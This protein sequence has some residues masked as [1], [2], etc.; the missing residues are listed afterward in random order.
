M[1]RIILVMLPGF[2][3]LQ[4]DS[5]PEVN[6]SYRSWVTCFNSLQVD[7]KLKE[8]GYDPYIMI[9]FQFL[10]GRLKT[11][12]RRTSTPKQLSF[13]SLQ[14]DSKPPGV[15]SGV[16]PVPCFNSLQVDS[17]PRRTYIFGGIYLCF[18]SLQVDSKRKKV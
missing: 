17:K 1:F 6:S 5:K 16:P 12:P 4:V 8:L 11:W 3:S 14:V 13:N 2:N 15:L 18:N 10:I 9:Q 7:S